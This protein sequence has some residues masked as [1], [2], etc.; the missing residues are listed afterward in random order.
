MY[1]IVRIMILYIIIYYYTV[2]IIPYHVVV[3][4]VQDIV[5]SLL[6]CIWYLIHTILDRVYYSVRLRARRGLGAQ[7]RFAHAADPCP[8]PLSPGLRNLYTPS[9]APQEI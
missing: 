7:R 2:H 4:S 8:G 9:Q 6:S 1:F 3:H 5:H